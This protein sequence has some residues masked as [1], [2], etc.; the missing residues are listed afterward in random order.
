VAEA[1]LRIPVD[2]AA[3]KRYIEAF[4]RYQTELRAQPDMWSG[5]NEQILEAVNAGDALVESITRQ[6]DAATRLGT[7]E[8]RN[9]QRRRRAAQDEDADEARAASWRRK[10][11]DHVQAL[12]R[13]TSKVT[14]TLKVA[15]LHL[16]KGS[17]GEAAGG[18]IEGIGGAIGAT[19][20]LG[21][22]ALVGGYEANKGVAGKGQKAIGIGANVGQMEGFQ[23]YLGKFADTTSGIDATANA[24]GDPAMWASF[25]KLGVRQRK[26]ESTAEVY[27][28]IV[29]R[30]TKIAE[31]ALDKNGNIRLDYA[32]AHGALDFFTPEELRRLI[33][34]D[35]AGKLAGDISNSLSS[36]KNNPL[37]NMDE[38]QKATDTAQKADVA[39]SLAADSAQDALAK[40]L[41]PAVIGAANALLDLTNGIEGPSDGSGGYKGLFRIRHQTPQEAAQS[42][43]SW[44]HW[45]SRV[46]STPLISFHH[47]GSMG[48]GGGG[49]LANNDGQ[50]LLRYAGLLQKAGFTREQ[51]LGIAAGSMAE[52]LGGNSHAINKKSGAIGL[53]QWLG[54]RK[55]ALYAMAKRDHADP[56]SFDEQFKYLLSE[57]KGGDVRGSRAIRNAKTVDEALHAMIYDFERPAAGRET[58]S[59]ISRGHAYL[60]K[61]NIRL[62]NHT[63]GSPTVVAN[64]AAKG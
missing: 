62:D 37:N 27:A 6:V 16:S 21:G 58:T 36:E 61:V 15:G 44:G 31:Q 55:R 32:S 30:S 40:K 14:R 19:V 22:A 17:I 34:R 43:E 10:A 48:S 33:A 51:A 42:K 46:M 60:A 59:D 28:D 9:A 57:L 18:L 3:F 39:L 29:K 8:E 35:K 49:A 52:S 2:D 56:L 64:S 20:A 4:K 63:G 50:H 1:V 38:I 11:L 47:A 26:G 7:V 24:L 23:N 5:V 25:A 41:R 54:A 45:F 12:S 13:S 53:G